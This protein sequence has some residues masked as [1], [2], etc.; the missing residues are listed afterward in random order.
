MHY[1]DDL[2]ALGITMALLLGTI[3][4]APH[5]PL[6]IVVGLPFV[7]FLP[8][9]ALIAAL[10][11]RRDD[12]DGVER[13]ALSLG[14]SLAVVPLIGL[15]LNYTPWGIRLVPI[16]VGLSV[17]T[18]GCAVAAW[19]RRARISPAERFPADVRPVLQAA[20]ALPWGTIALSAVIVGGLLA[21]GFKTGVLGGTR[22]GEAFTEFYV[23]GPQ[24]K[25]EGYPTRLFLGDT[26]HVILGVINH[27][28][29]PAR[30][31]VEIRAGADVLGRIGPLALAD[32]QKWEQPV[33]FT[34]KHPGPRVK[35]EFLLWI[36]GRPTPYRNLHLWVRVTPL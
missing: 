31:R 35:V 13:L 23:L 12:L 26:A 2:A 4:V 19:R 15:V 17:F 25:A 30:Y 20:R 1:T 3:A 11:P 14:L 34:P 36:D 22:V 33:Q 10:Y 24:G 6:R 7:L 32:G 5:S 28:G 9:Y 18:G 8:G 16:L 21:L 29:H 27:E